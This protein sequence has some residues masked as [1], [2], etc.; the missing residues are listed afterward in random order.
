MTKMSQFFRAGLIAALAAAGASAFAQAG[1]NYAELSRISTEAKRQFVADKTA[2][3]MLAAQQGLPTRYEDPKTGQIFEIM[4]IEPDGHPVYYLTTNVNAALTTRASRVYPGGGAGLSLTG[5]GVLLSVWDGGAVRTTHQE[6]TGRATQSDSASSFSAHSTHVS[7]TMIAA[8]VS[9]ARKGMSYEATL[10]CFDWNSD[11][12]ETAAA[13]AAATPIRVSNHSY[14]T[15]QGW[16][17]GDFGSGSGWYWFGS[18][19]VSQTEDYLFGF[20]SSQARSWDNVAVAAPF[21]LPV[22]A[23]GNDRGEGPSNTA[24]GFVRSGSSWVANSVARDKDGGA[25]G[26]DSVNGVKGA[27]NVLSVGAVADVPTYTGPGS[28]AMSSFSC[29]GPTD[30]GRI[31]PDVVGNGISLSSS[32]STSDTAYATMSGTSMASPN[33]SGS[34]GLLIQHYRATHSGADMR[35]ATLKGLVIH[36]ADECGAATGPDY[37]YGWGLMNT[38]AAADVITKD[39]VNPSVIREQDLADGATFTTRVTS[40]GTSPL[41][42]TICWTDP[43]ATVPGA[44]LDPTTLMLRNDLDIRVSKDGTTYMPYVLDPANPANA[45]ITGDNFRDNVEVL[46]IPAPSAGS[47]LV[48]VTHKNSLVSGNPQNFSLIITGP[49]HDPLLTNFGVNGVWI[50][51]TNSTNG[52][53]TLSQPAPAGGLDLY[54]RY[55]AGMFIYS[56]ITIPAGETTKSFVIKG[57]A[58]VDANTPYS[59]FVDSGYESIG[60]AGTLVPVRISTLNLAPNPVQ[61][62]TNITMTVGLNG[63]APAGGLTLTV[64]RSPTFWVMAPPT[65]FIPAGQASVSVDIPIRAGAPAINNARLTVVQSLT[66]GGNV[67]LSKLFNITP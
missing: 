29:W 28:V 62:G 43:A 56:P 41:R 16:A 15:I 52:T 48:T 59:V 44:A 34:L 4:K 63:P 5:N 67:S 38:E 46:D 40:D 23:A 37:I 57:T 36:T 54:P 53:V 27:K 31:K 30:D 13:A 33:V 12:S 47:Y 65:V 26:Y 24:T 14:T 3:I 7:G 60:V 32:T 11:L 22:W 21:Y 45:A 35:A 58:P 1:T 39:G 6:L 25:T 17:N 49:R 50:T 20:Y 2:A 19:S 66:G 64:D 9:A 55:P 18:T 61:S 51:G 42:F 10:H 8:G